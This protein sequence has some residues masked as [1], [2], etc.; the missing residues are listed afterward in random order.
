MMD[1]DDTIRNLLHYG[2]EESENTTKQEEDHSTENDVDE[3]DT[4]DNVKDTD[5]N[6]KDIEP[7]AE[8]SLE[9]ETKK[10][11]IPQQ[12]SSMDNT[13]NEDENEEYFSS[14]SEPEKDEKNADIDN[15][16][17][18]YENT[19]EK[20]TMS[21]KKKII[22]LALSAV[23]IFILMTVFSM[24]DTGM[25]GNYK[26]NFSA[27]LIT[28]FG[29]MGIDISKKPL[30]TVGPVTDTSSISEDSVAGDINQEQTKVKSTPSATEPPEY[31]TEVEFSA[32]VPFESAS[33]SDFM[34]YKKGIVCAKTNYLCY[35]NSSGETEWEIATSVVDPIIKAEGDYILIAQQGGTKLCLYNGNELLYDTDT[36]GNILTCSVSSNGDVVVVLNRKSYKG[37]FSV[38]N[39]D[40][41]EIY[42]WSSGSRLI[43]SADIAA[44]SR[45]VAVSLLDTDSTVKSSILLF[46]INK[47]DSY[48]YADFD[49]TI[50]FDVVFVDNNINAFGDNA[51][52]G[53]NTSG[54]VLY[55]KRF[56]DVDLINYSMD[57]T[58]TKV[59]VFNSENIPMMNIYNSSG[60]LKYTITTQSQAD[61][62]DIDSYN[63]IYNDNR[64]IFLGKP[65]SRNISKFTASMDIKK[66]ILLNSKSFVIV[67]SNSLEFV[68]M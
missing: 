52:V 64:D 46:N 63:I 61:Y 58:G 17:Y 22:I 27:N 67:Y 15:D 11:E 66:L 50:L 35:I 68:E 6:L 20:N 45:R 28:L 36:D 59:M 43:L 13:E 12:I 55:D 57:K 33:E 5:D 60:V 40:G 9:G 16:E 10:I 51:M 1:N 54:K 7:E 42:S 3:K 8:E 48:A 47:E 18:F 44:S 41:N 38:Y 39:N 25:V 32:L 2:D 14:D 23:G 65:N 21:K 31:N 29:N 4:D 37:A 62:V 34:V 26:K 30:P 49:D 24:I 56:D 53:M 19:E